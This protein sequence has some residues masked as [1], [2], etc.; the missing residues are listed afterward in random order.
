MKPMKSMRFWGVSLPI[1]FITGLVLLYGGVLDP[2]LGDMRASVVVWGLSAIGIL[3]FTMWMFRRFDR[4]QEDLDAALILERRQGAQLEAL[5]EATLLLNRHLGLATVL[6]NVVDLARQVLG[7]DYGALAVMGESRTIQAFLTS[8]ITEE[9]RALLGPSPEGHGLL[10]MVIENREPLLVNDIAAHPKS[11]GFPPHHPPMRTLVAVPVISGEEVIGSLYVTNGPEG[12][13]FEESDRRVLERFAA[14]AAVAIVNA[15]LYEDAQ[16]VSALEERERIAMDLHDGVIQSIYGTSLALKSLEGRLPP[17]TGG[18]IDDIIGRLDRVTQDVRDYVY[19]LRQIHLKED[20]FVRMME[21]LVE[22]TR[23]EGGPDI[24]L[25][26][27]GDFADLPRP[28]QTELWHVAHEA[29]ANAIRH[30]GAQRVDVII[31]RT[32]EGLT[33]AVQDDGRGFSPDV[34]A[35]P[36]HQGI[37]NMR[38]RVDQLGGKFMVVSAPGRGTTIAVDVPITD[39]EDA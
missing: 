13:A 10:G 5:S 26:H 6:Q 29:L 27:A 37:R 22:T 33:L 24:H 16:R 3:F 7:A 25:T 23:T 21:G 11:V 34:Q 30:G 9:T 39:Q 36:G 8:G 2:L 14:Q 1:L 28:Y 4:Y 18:E 31:H 38:Q 19:D 35:G 15:Q 32:E 17:D 20:N 12:R